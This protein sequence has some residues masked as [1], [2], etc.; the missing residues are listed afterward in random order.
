MGT[1]LLTLAFFLSNLFEDCSLC[2]FVERLSIVLDG[3]ML[4]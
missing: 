3:K 1:K 2:L 4:F